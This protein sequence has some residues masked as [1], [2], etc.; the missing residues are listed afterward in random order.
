MNSNELG[1][2]SRREVSLVVDKKIV[3]RD[4]CKFNI[5]KDIPEVQGSEELAPHGSC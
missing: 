4:L 5:S 2:I 3:L 1:E